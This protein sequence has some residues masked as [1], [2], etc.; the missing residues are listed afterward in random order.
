MRRGPL[1]LLAVAAAAFPAAASGASV[2]VLHR[3]GRAT[4][5]NDPF[6]TGPAIT[7]APASTAAAPH[8]RPSPRARTAVASGATAHPAGKPRR[9]PPVTVFSELA[10]IYRTHAISATAYRGY[11]NGLESALAS[12]RRLRGTRRIELD[13][14]TETLHQIAVSHQLTASRLPA[15]F[16]TLQANQRWWTS[17][18][19]LT[20]DQRVEFAGSQLVWEFYPGQGIQL[21]VLGSFGKANGLYT[22]GPAD[23]PQMEQLLSELIPLAA[24]RGGGLTWEYYFSFDGGAPPWTSA[25]SQATGLEAL[26]RA[27][28]ATGVGSYLGVGVRALPIFGVPPPVGV[29]VRTARGIRFLQYTFAPNTAIINAFL[30]TLIGLDTFATVSGNPTAASLFA[31]GN[32]EAQAELPGYD[33]GAWSLYQPGVEDTLSYHELVTGF[34]ATLCTLTATPVYCTTAEHFEAYLTRPPVLTQLTFRGSATAT[35]SL[36]F[37]L[38]KYSHVGIVVTRGAATVFAT[39]GDFG[40][41]VQGVALPRLAAGSYGVRLAATDLAGNFARISGSLQITR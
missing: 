12:E 35:G 23:Y 30:Q 5:R 20:A 3:D 7:P 16:A 9:P 24:R 11:V 18:P 28:R 32:A 39:S 2:T 19:L 10:R 21:Q 27:Y 37:Q 31:A 41:G 1:V 4:V 29:D 22:G 34:L 15:L 33:T 36:R 8:R 6:V 38:S 25:M 17:G 40:Y 14:V 26:A 13:A